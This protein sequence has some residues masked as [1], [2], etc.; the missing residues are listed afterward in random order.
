MR[1]E[2]SLPGIISPNEM[3]VQN[4]ICQWFSH[5]LILHTLILND[6]VFILYV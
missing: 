4:L 1:M 6:M 3:I 2:I 5:S